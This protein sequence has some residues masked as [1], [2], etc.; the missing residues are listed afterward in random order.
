MRI[1][2]YIVTG[3]LIHKNIFVGMQPIWVAVTQH[4][5][6]CSQLYTPGSPVICKEATAGWVSSQLIMKKKP[7]EIMDHDS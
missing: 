1:Q 5:K 2:K 3:Q 4:T 7:Y 6:V